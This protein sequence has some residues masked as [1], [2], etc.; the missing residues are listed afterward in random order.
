[1]K[2][3]VISRYPLLPIEFGATTPFPSHS[4][5]N[6]PLR[7]RKFAP[8]LNLSGFVRICYSTYREEERDGENNW[9]KALEESLSDTIEMN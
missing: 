2:V 4:E 8:G 5:T 6:S 7:D 3:N 1:M 9:S